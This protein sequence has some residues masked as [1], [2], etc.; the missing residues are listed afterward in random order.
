MTDL[1]ITCV[2]SDGT[3]ADF[4]IEGVGGGASLLSRW[5]HDID[6]AIR[7]I[8][9]GL[10]RYYTSHGGKSAWVVVR[11]HPQSRRKYLTTENDAYTAN[12]LSRLTSCPL[13]A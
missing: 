11:V 6:V 8:E 5:F 1:L 13:A 2:T 9:C 12:N 7:N 3:D 4:R 10:H